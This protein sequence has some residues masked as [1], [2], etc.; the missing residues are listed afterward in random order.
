[1]IRELLPGDPVSIGPYKLL[2]RLG[3][4]GMG[5]VYLARS[6]GGRTVA[7]KVIQPQLA[8]EPGFRTRFAREVAAAKGVSGMFTALVVDADTQGLHPWLA[9]AYVAGPSLSEAVES[10]G[11]LPAESVLALAA[12]L[13]EGLQAI[14]AVGVVHRDLKP[15]NVLLA[16]DGPRVID[17]GISR[18]REASMLTQAGTVMGSPGYLSPEQAEGLPVGPPSDIFSLGSVLVFAATGEGPFGSGLPAALMYRVVSKEPDLSGVPETVRAVVERC[19]DKDADAR[20]TPGE[21][22]ADLDAM[23]AGVGVVTPQW[24]PGPLTESLNRYVPTMQTPATPARPTSRTDTTPATPGVPVSAVAP[25]AVT[26]HQSVPAVDPVPAAKQEEPGSGPVIPIAVGLAA[27]A[28]A[29]VAVA[30]VAGVAEAADEVPVPTGAGPAG[31]SASDTRVEAAPTPAADPTPVPDAPPARDDTF[32]VPAAGLAGLGLAAKELADKAPSG[33]GLGG[34]ATVGMSTLPPLVQPP[35]AVTPG[36]GTPVGLGNAGGAGP[37]PAAPV[38]PLT[39]AG[40]VGAGVIGGG[41]IGGGVIGGGLAGA[42]ADGAATGAGAVGGNG[43]VGGNGTGGGNVTP[44]P[45]P[46]RR[47]LIIAAAAAV[48]I[49][50]GIGAALGLSGGGSPGHP[51]SGPDPS[52][53]ATASS[54]GHA[55]TSASASASKSPTHP[56]THKPSPTKNPKPRKSPTRS[57]SPTPQVTSPGPVIS[58]TAPD[59]QPTTPPDTQPATTAPATHP[60]TPPTTPHTTPPPPPPP[61]PPQSIGTYSGATGTAC[62]ATTSNPTG[63]GFGFSF[64]NDSSSSVSIDKFSTGGGLIGEGSIGPHSSAGYTA[65]D[66]DSWRVVGASGGCLGQFDVFGAGGVTIN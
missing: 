28:A 19:L 23:G 48:V 30:G 66:G 4:G 56:P 39:G 54:G 47:R 36:T 25:P 29:G 53:V 64:V 15:S 8:E 57:S 65:Y 59:I 60:V 20:P 1:M 52:L 38:G 51:V 24:L 27:A 62:I 7:V 49:V 18:A 61:P 16:A 32:L 40:A 46:S 34:Q 50:A 22:L 33:G 17:F 9:T 41:V 44:L 10:Q 21:L 11:P 5:V 14:H 55:S 6:P 31:I 58:S 26:I 63:G 13:A 37:G 3:Q 43:S 2:G 12:G 42:A 35:V 45:R